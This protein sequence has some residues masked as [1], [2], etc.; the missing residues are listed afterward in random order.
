MITIRASDRGPGI[1]DVELVLSGRYRSR[2]GLGK[3]LLGVK[4]LANK[5]EIDSGPTGTRVEA[6]IAL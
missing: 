2:T 4:R 6:E 5:F 1:P 3:G